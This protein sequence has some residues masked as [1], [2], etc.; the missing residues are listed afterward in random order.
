MKVVEFCNPTVKGPPNFV[1]PPN[2]PSPT[3][4]RQIMLIPFV[5]MMVAQPLMSCT[6]LHKYS[7]SSRET[8]INFYQHNVIVFNFARY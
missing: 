5:N 3:P 8:H 1:T 2:I 4:L 6:Y 7:I